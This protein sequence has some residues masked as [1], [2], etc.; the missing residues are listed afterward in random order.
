MAMKNYYIGKYGTA[1]I[2]ETIPE[3]YQYLGTDEDTKHIVFINPRKGY[4]LAV[5]L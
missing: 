2:V 4:T 1:E 3:G 5:R